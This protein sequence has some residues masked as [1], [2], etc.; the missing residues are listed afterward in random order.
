LEAAGQRDV[1]VFCP[2][3]VWGMDSELSYC[4][5]LNAEVSPGVRLSLWIKTIFLFIEMFCGIKLSLSLLWQL[6]PLSAILTG[7]N[8]TT[9][10][11]A[12]QRLSKV[13][14]I[15]ISIRNKI[16][17]ICQMYGVEVKLCKTC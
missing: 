9:L 8:K 1:F 12:P 10:A 6:S 16:M 5:V 14:Q 4:N 17:E 13:D 3:V 11:E 2:A 15:Y 7:I